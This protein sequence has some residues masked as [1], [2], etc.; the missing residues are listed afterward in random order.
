MA[1]RLFDPNDGLMKDTPS[2]RCASPRGLAR[3][4]DLRLLS[5]LRVVSAGVVECRM[6]LLRMALRRVA[7][8]LLPPDMACLR[9]GGRSV[10]ADLPIPRRR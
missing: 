9:V 3:G 7:Y 5:S 2:R 8:R 1:P 10:E 6:V 4:R